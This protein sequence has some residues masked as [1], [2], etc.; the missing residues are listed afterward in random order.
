MSPTCSTWNS[1]KHAEKRVGR[2]EICLK[3]LQSYWF[4]VYRIFGIV[5]LLLFGLWVKTAVDSLDNQNSS[6]L[7]KMGQFLSCGIWLCTQ[8]VTYGYKVDSS[9]WILKDNNIACQYWQC[10]ESDMYTQGI[11]KIADDIYS[12]LECSSRYTQED[13]DFKSGVHMHTH[14]HT[15]TSNCQHRYKDL[16]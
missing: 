7:D 1:P 6:G 13:W 16:R 14:T 8:G 12:Q 2:P 4:Q 9:G 5:I 10:R 11:Y 15:H 3:M